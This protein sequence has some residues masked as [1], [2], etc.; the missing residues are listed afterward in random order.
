MD[1]AVSSAH[2]ASGSAGSINPDALL[3]PYLA[4]FA[5]WIAVGSLY[6]AFVCMHNDRSTKPIKWM[7]AAL[8]SLGTLTVAYGVAS[9]AVVRLIVR[10]FYD[11]FL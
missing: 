5:A 11:A 6:V 1:D 8:G 9:F 2:L 4:Y 7:F 3:V 10:L